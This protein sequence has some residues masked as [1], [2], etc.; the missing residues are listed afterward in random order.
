MESTPADSLTAPDDA[1]PRR[2]P[3]RLTLGDCFALFVRQSSPPVL[4]LALVAAGA[5][6]VALGHFDWRDLVVIAG[7]LALT[8]PVEWLIHVYLLHA[9]PLQVFGRRVDLLAA[10]E[11]RA[12][13]RRP[14]VLGGVLIPAY[15]LPIFFAQI[16]VT[17]WLVS[18]PIHW[19]FGGD[20][21]AHAA[22]G[23]LGALAILTTYEWCHF[24]I[25]TP[26][27]PRGR[28]YRSIW[29]G[30]R[31]HHFKNEH[32]WFGVTSTV[33]DHLLRTAP[34]QATVPKS[35]TARSL[36]GDGLGQPLAP[37]S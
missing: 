24:L 7:L 4:A 26:Y 28:Y 18:F 13:H 36:G 2:D 14:S 30:H 20:R 16:A 29:R 10:R 9:R 5:L 25:H 27:R 12:H 3:A 8:P 19:I 17:V 21:L 31:L 11:H 37:S 22:T 34:D 15:A 32:Y 33:A 1:V 35:G 6:R 23:L